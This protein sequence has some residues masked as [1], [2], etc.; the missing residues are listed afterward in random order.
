MKLDTMKYDSIRMSG[1]AVFRGVVLPVLAAGLAAL[2]VE[3]GAAQS[4]EKLVISDKT[5][6]AWV[7][8]ANLSQRGGSVLTLEKPGG[9]F[10]AMVFG[11]IAA[12]RWMAGS[13][14]F[15]RTQTAQ[16][17]SPAETCD[18]K[19]LVQI[20]IVY[21]GK[22]VTIYR[23]GVK[24]ADY[25]VGSPERFSSDSLVLMGLRH[26]DASADNRFLVG[27]IDDARIYGVALSSQQIAALQPN[28]PSD[29]APVAWWDFEAGRA[30]DRMRLY[31]TATLFGDARIA[32]GRLHLDKPG[33]YLM[34]TKLAPQAG[35]DLSNANSAALRCGRSC[36]A[37]PS[38]LATISSRLRELACRLTPMGRFTGK[39]SITSFTFSRMCAATTGA[40]FP[41]QICSTGGIIPR[42]WYPA[43]S[44]V[45]ASSTKRGGR[46]S[47][48]TRW[49]RAMPW[50]W[51]WM[52]N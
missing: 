18:G 23:N 38:A 32:D 13:N 21:R 45:T 30:S 1:F 42:A 12:S 46:P 20:A 2:T 50:Q 16:N 10:D 44:A 28:Q 40:M 9:T 51:P 26:I 29:P 5:L 49:V 48:I 47:A 41:V 25:T 24:Y 39:A 31:P 27:S 11:E 22:Q 33:A 14:N 35:V 3:A 4:V 7:A 52:M 6:V 37:I 34:G 19:G 15:S 8:P 17:S 43:C 36:S